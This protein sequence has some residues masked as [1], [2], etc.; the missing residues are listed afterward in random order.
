MSS[1]ANNALMRR[2]GL[3]GWL[4]GGR[5]LFSQL[6]GWMVPYTGSLGAEVEELAPGRAR[7]RLRQRRAV[8]NHLGSVHAAALANLGEM[9]LGLAMTAL[10]PP[11]GRFI[12]TRLEVDYLK[13]ARGT[14]L[15]VVE[16]P[17]RVWPEDDT[18]QGEA[19]IFD[20]SQELCCRV[21]ASLKVGRKRS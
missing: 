14:L 10:Q 9:T 12:P 6:I 20:D 18:W 15:C 16:L 19:S 1:A 21:V 2:W 4:P 11:G 3:C 8:S 13:K 17:P 7:V 5:W